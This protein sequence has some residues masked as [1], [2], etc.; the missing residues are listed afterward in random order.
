MLGLLAQSPLSS[1]TDLFFSAFHRP[2]LDQI[3]SHE[4]LSAGPIP[5]SLPSSVLHLSPN[6]A[7][8]ESTGEIYVVGKQDLPLAQQR[9]LIKSSTIG[10]GLRQPFGSRDVNSDTRSSTTAS[11]LKTNDPRIDTQRILRTAM[12]MSAAPAK[13]IVDTPQPRFRIFDEGAAVS[14]PPHANRRPVLLDKPL[15][16]NRRP[17]LH[18]KPPHARS[19][20]LADEVLVRRTKAMSLSERQ[21]D[22]LRFNTSTGSGA[23]SAFSAT[24]SMGADTEVL[25][26]MSDQLDAVLEVTLSRK[27]MYSPAMPRPVPSIYG[28][29]TWVTRYVDY[30][31]KYGLGF[32]LNDGSSG[33]YFN[34]STKSVLESDSDTFQYIERRKSEEND[35]GLRRSDASVETFTLSMFPDSLKKK[36]TLL[37]HFRNYLIEQ[38]KNDGEHSSPPSTL[39]EQTNLV[40][41]KKWLRTKHAILFRMSNQTVQVIFYDQT[42]ILMTPDARYITYVDK[43]RARVTYHFNDE[44]IGSSAE[45]EKRLKYTQECMSM[46]LS[47]RRSS[48]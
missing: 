5:K 44:L 36:V 32:L 13:P 39:S 4:F 27:G 26:R 24:S 20:S 45:M 31:S 23:M 6:W 18:D 25:L 11:N 1:L 35:C 14:A 28:P 46:L 41:V 21:N 19:V 48:P 17:V 29:T 8:D 12:A 9:G 10:S 2:S 38:Q 22:Q 34:D 37:K 43:T 30:T 7:V 15:D 3:E 47:G 33:V 16:A 40:Y 42:E